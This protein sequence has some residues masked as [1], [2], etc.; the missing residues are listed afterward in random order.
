MGK[1][2]PPTSAVHLPLRK[3]SN[4]SHH[5]VKMIGKQPGTRRQSS[6]IL[7]FQLKASVALRQELREKLLNRV[8]G[9]IVK[10]LQVCF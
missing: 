5:K 7:P 4:F 9:R 10:V 1:A 3:S 6:S 2:W 8:L